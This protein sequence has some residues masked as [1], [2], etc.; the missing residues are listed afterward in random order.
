MFSAFYD[1]NLEMEFQ[2]SYGNSMFNVFSNCQAVF[3]NGC[4]VSHSHQ[5]ERVEN[6]I[7]HIIYVT[8]P[9]IIFI[10]VDPS[11]PQ[12]LRDFFENFH[13]IGLVKPLISSPTPI[14]HRQYGNYQ[15]RTD[16]QNVYHP[17]GC[18]ELTPRHN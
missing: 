11:A 13:V 10:N 12:N 5:Q 2:G 6:I 16:T 9:K 18:P 4:A 1:I 8:I 3:Y 15:Q 17:A 7:S 14:K